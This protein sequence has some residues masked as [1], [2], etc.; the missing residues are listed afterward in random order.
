M[1]ANRYD[2]LIRLIAEKESLSAKNVTCRVSETC[3]ILYKLGNIIFDN[4]SLLYLE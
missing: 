1:I 3:I 2:K 4:F